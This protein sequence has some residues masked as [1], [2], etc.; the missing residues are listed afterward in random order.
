MTLAAA[1][2]A[3]A[4]LARPEARAQQGRRPARQ[5]TVF[6]IVAVPNA[7]M[8]DPKLEA[9][10]PQLRK[11][12]P[13][14]GFT[15]LDVQSKRLTSG[16]TVTCD[17]GGGSTA[18]TTLLQPLDDNGKVQLRCEIQLGGMPQH[19]TIVATP[20]NQLFFCDKLRDDGSRLLIGIGAR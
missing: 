14:H 18:S 16:Q 2:L 4:A 1:V 15:L 10:A 20:P 7:S 6:G 3:L 8:V 12:L 19:A 5:V 9:V 13:N 11:L 17:L